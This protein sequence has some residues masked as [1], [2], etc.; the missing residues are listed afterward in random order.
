LTPPLLVRAQV[1]NWPAEIAA[2]AGFTCGGDVVG[3]WVA[4][5]ED[6]AGGPDGDGDVL[7]AGLVADA[8]ATTRRLTRIVA[9]KR[10]S[11]GRIPRSSGRYF[12]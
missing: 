3:N 4:D 10:E 11:E 5:S 6:A 8:Q 1:W 12:L 7:G 2:I 9:G